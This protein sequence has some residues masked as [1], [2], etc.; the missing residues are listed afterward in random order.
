MNVNILYTALLVCST[1]V[2]FAVAIKITIKYSKQF[3]IVY[4]KYVMVFVETSIQKKLEEFIRPIE[5]LIMTNDG[6]NLC[7][8]E[9]DIEF[10]NY[11]ENTNIFLENKTNG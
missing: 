10:I 6:E 3:K 8:L 9:E 5:F 1:L 4:N 11:L 7:D 2:F